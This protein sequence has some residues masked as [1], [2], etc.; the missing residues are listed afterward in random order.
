MPLRTPHHYLVIEK[1]Q[2]VETTL[3]DVVV[4]IDGILQDAWPGMVRLQYKYTV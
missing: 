1:P 2:I 4:E 3:E